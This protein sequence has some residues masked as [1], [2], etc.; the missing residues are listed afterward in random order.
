MVLVTIIRVN[1]VQESTN[2]GFFPTKK[3]QVQSIISG[4][5]QASF[6][7]GLTHIDND[8]SDIIVQTFGFAP[9]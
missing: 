1:G 5:I 3:S 7:A 6:R 9:S 4:C 8:N 2:G